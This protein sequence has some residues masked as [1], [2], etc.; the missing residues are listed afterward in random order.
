MKTGSAA[1]RGA[2][3]TL[4]STPDSAGGLSLPPGRFFS[5]IAGVLDRA[6]GTA[7]AG[8][9]ARPAACVDYI[10]ALE[11]EF[12]AANVEKILLEEMFEAVV[13]HRVLPD[14]LGRPE[15][16]PRFLLE[17]VLKVTSALRSLPSR[18]P[19]EEKS[20]LLPSAAA[21][22]SGLPSFD[23][24]SCFAAAAA[25]LTGRDRFRTDRVFKWVNGQLI[26]SELNS[27]KPLKSFFGFH[28]VRAIFQD[29]FRDFSLGRTN[30]PL[31]VYSLPGYGK[32][33]MT[34]SYAMAAENTVLILPEPEALERAWDD[35]IALLAR[36][37]DHKF[38]IFFDDI[39]PRNVDWYNFRTNV[40]GAFS[41]PGNIM[42]VL[43]SNFEFPASILSRGRK[44]S[45]PVFD[46]LRCT[47]MIEDFLR[48]F[49]LK[50]LP[51]NLVSLIGADY[52]EEFGQKKFSEL[53]P[54][55]L[56]RYLSIYAQDREKR[57][58]IA[59]LAMG[60][61]ITRPDAELFYSFNIDLM[62][63]LYGDEYIARL[64]EEKLRSL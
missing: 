45:Y 29:H 52:T 46:E 51:P 7:P 40:G 6:A 9:V 34:V 37:P 10:N 56:I 42:P 61:M 31:L 26:A 22:F 5:L 14:D 35:L 23:D 16:T 59:E 38:I 32:T 30:I 13:R 8:P 33:S 4:F 39:D 60:Q 27:A 18:L 1:A 3:D 15:G 12:G 19:E 11:L 58:L 57:R 41:L 24:T 54:R 17:A 21:L 20:R 48:D 63:S 47:E 43:S 44:V 36:R 55:T 53:S 49:G 2:L 62:R 64:R 28:G 50:T 25:A